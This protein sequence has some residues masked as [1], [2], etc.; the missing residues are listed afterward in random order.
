LFF[1][2]IVLQAHTTTDPANTDINE[3]PASFKKS[4]FL[5]TRYSSP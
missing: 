1:Y 4:F 2:G 5:K 3:V